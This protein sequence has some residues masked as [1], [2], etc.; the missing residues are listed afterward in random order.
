MRAPHAL[1]DGR[2]DAPVDK[3]ILVSVLSPTGAILLCQSPQGARPRKQ[4]RPGGRDL[5]RRGCAP[6]PTRTLRGGPECPTPRPRDAHVRVLARDH[7]RRTFP[8]SPR[9]RGFL[10]RRLRG[11]ARRGSMQAACDRGSNAVHA[12]ASSE[13]PRA[14][15][16]RSSRPRAGAT[17]VRSGLPGVPPTSRRSAPAC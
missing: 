5:C 8:G 1:S 9:T 6:I 16:A 10:T 17:R 15:S 7:R 2:R 4:R 11:K 13:N 14:S 12:G 3:V